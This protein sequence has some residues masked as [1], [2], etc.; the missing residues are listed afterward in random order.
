MTDAC[1]PAP[2]AGPKSPRA[3]TIRPPIVVRQP[4]LEL[5][6]RSTSERPPIDRYWWGGDP[7]QTHFLNALSST[8]PFG[9]A[10]FVRSVRHY[11]D[12][13]DDPDLAK[14]IRAFAAQEGQHSRLH[15]DHVELLLAQGYTALETRNRFFDRIVRWH[16]RRTPAFALA[17]TASLEHL[18]ALLARQVLD[19][20]A[21]WTRTMDPRMRSLWRWHAL[22]ESEHKAVA[23]D[24]YRAMDLPYGLL[25]F[26][27]V[28]STFDLAIETFQRM[29]YM[30]W[31]DGRLFDGAAWR[32]GGRFLFGRGGFLRGLGADYR[33]WFRRDFHPDQIDDRATIER[34]GP[35]V[36][37]EIAEWAAASAAR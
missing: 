35:I 36:D 19:E 37:A 13:L 23:F 32:R 25:V 29:L 24:T 7:F 9:E 34:L 21:D 8:F 10:F 30:F 1:S 4:R 20:E 22:E 2:D 3:S 28:L 15:D 5:G 14:E 26:A 17:V 11:A 31:K 18:T 16:N 6:N 12:R 27:M 33:A